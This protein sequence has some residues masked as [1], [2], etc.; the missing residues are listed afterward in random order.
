MEIADPTV[1]GAAEVAEKAQNPARAPV[2][3]LVVAT[4]NRTGQLVRLLDSLVGQSRRGFEV[5][6]VDQNPEGV[7]QPILAP[8]QGKLALTHVACPRGVSRA[9]N[10]GIRLA[11]GDLICFPD[12]DCWYPPRALADIVAFFETHPAVDMVLGRTV[13]AQGRELV[14]RFLARSEPVS[15]RNA[16]LAG[17][18]NA[19]FVRRGAV[20]AI[21]GFDEKL[22]PGSGTPFNSGED[23]DFVL[24]ALERQVRI[25]FEHALLI[26]HDQVDSAIDEKFLTRVAGYSIGYGRVLRKHGYGASYLLYR[27]ARMLPRMLIAAVARNDAQVKF[28][29]V[30]ISGAVRGYF[31]PPPH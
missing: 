27:I 14:S 23:T 26:H 19:L 30:W 24:T 12:D 15:R 21:G 17:N 31:A 13:D 20:A 18:T 25:Y 22:G 11:R 28:R 2:A 6:V 7:L 1:A 5:I 8:Y 9:R 3:S 10:L 4:V 29:R 16:W